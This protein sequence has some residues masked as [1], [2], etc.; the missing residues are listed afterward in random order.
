M[1][2]TWTEYLCVRPARSPGDF[3]LAV[4]GTFRGGRLRPMQDDSFRE[5][6]GRAPSMLADVLRALEWPSEDLSA[7]QQALAD[8]VDAWA[9]RSAT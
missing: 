4:C 3:Q 2:D 7:V 1:V 5:V 9:P 8:L 6:T